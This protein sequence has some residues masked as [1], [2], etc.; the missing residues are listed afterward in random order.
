MTPPTATDTA[1]D[2]ELIARV[3]GGDTDAYGLLFERHRDA[4]IRLAR[5][6]SSSDAD[7]LV[8]EAFAKLLPLLRSG[9]GPDL[10]FRAYLLTTVRRLHLDRLR[11]GGRLQ[12]AGLQPSTSQCHSTVCQRSGNDANAFAAALRSKPVTAGSVKGT[13]GSNGAMSP[14]VCSRPPE[15][16]RSRCSRRTVVSR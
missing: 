15:R 7:D 8:A 4:A 12:T 14:A 11:S 16:S 10:A 13:P 9:G 2:S 6:L 1:S 5:Q 3:R